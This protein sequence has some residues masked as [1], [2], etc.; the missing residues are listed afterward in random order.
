MQQASVV[1][2]GSDT[3]SQDT[4]NTTQDRTTNRNRNTFRNRQ[5]QERDSSNDSSDTKS[6]IHDEPNEGLDEEDNLQVV[7]LET[8][9]SGV[10]TTNS[11]LRDESSQ[12][13]QSEF[14]SP[15]IRLLTYNFTNQIVFLNATGDPVME[16]YP[17]VAAPALCVSDTG[18]DNITVRWYV[19]LWRKGHPLRTNKFLKY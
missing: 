3:R 13:S 18:G 9:Q 10:K 14:S 7:S 15:S 2:D 5:G 4:T 12:S 6:S 17:V 16:K 8:E 11:T 1:G 19:P